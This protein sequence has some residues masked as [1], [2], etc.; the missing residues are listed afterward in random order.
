LPLN[1]NYLLISGQQN[2]YLMDLRAWYAHQKVVLRC[3]NHRNGFPGI[4]PGQNGLYQDSQGR[5]WITSSSVLSVLD[6][7]KLNF[8]SEPTRTH[9]THLNGNR[10]P[11]VQFQRDSVFRLPFGI[12]NLRVGFESVGDD[13]PFR[14][15]YS[16]NI[17]GITDGWTAWQEEPVLSLSNMASG[18]YM[19]K[20]KSRT[21]STDYD[22]SQ[23]AT[24]RFQVRVW[25]W[26]SPYFPYYASLLV[27]MIGGLAGYFYWRNQRS[28]V[29]MQEQLQ[30]MKILEAQTAQAQMN[31]H[32]IF[33]VLNTLLGQVDKGQTADVNDN[34]L[35]LASLMRSYLAASLSLD[36]SRDA[37]EKRM[38]TLDEE[39]RLLHQY[40]DFEQLQYPEK[41]D[42]A[43][44]VS[45]DLATDFH[46]VP[47]LLIQPFVE[48]AV[49]YGVLPNKDKKGH[50]TI[51]FWLEADEVVACLIED[52][53]IGREESR[54]RRAL[55]LHTHRSEGT[56]LVRKRAKILNQLN[57]FIDYQT[58]DRPAGGTS[59]LIKFKD[60][61]A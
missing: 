46:R 42:Y 5:V 4:E 44:E 33:N 27:L 50:V 53:G 17:E 59:V 60:N 49:K 34:I 7:K 6:T 14:S 15:Q 9:F 21:G 1:D 28:Q 40:I 2:L 18:T 26:Q 48:N 51:K 3:F 39:L 52:D 58:T 47:P 8:Q 37:L 35:K 19:L 43:I 25:P 36:G 10:L 57:Y 32:F 31:P 54:R 45:P 55:A 13:K 41:F 11:F 12:G 24:L 22:N 23:E 30:T 61:L 16:Y 20:V 56:D 38:I 29:A